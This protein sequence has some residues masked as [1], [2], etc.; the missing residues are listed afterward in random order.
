LKKLVSR[1]KAYETSAIATEARRK[2]SGTARPTMPA[3]RT[4]FN[5]IAAVG[6]MIPTEIA[7]ASQTL[8]SRRRVPRG[9]SAAAVGSA[10]S[11]IVNYLLRRS[12]PG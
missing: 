9:R 1:M 8:S 10:I 4:P 6:A 3:G 2:A 12:L 7:N 5:A 11:L